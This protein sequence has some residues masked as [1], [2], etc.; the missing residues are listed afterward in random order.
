MGIEG[1]V[2]SLTKCIHKMLKAI[3]TLISKSIAEILT[4]FPLMLGTR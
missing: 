3:K 1:N 4:V 2:L